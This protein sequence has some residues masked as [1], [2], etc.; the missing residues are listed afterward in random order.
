MELSKSKKELYDTYFLKEDLIKL[1]KK[2]N[3]PANG[4]KGNLLEYIRNFI[5][6]EPVEKI[7]IKQKINN[8]GFE[9]SLEKITDGNY[10]NNEIHRAF[11]IKIIGGHFKFNVLFMN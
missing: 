1:C 5:E 7:K 4:S 3:L 9:P 11:F 10:S 2:Y 8:N 6:N